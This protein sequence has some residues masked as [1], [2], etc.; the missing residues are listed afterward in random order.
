MYQ[1]LHQYIP[2]HKFVSGADN[3]ISDGPSHS[4]NFTNTALLSYMDST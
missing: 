3:G 1:R 2:H 4:H